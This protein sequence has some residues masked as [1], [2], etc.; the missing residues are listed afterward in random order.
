[1]GKFFPPLTTSLPA[2]IEHV[3][4]SRVF[5]GIIS[6]LW[7]QLAWLLGPFPTL[8][9]LVHLLNPAGPLAWAKE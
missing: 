1:M 3:F 2:L 5:Y 8:V 7:R 9:F 6:L 4:F